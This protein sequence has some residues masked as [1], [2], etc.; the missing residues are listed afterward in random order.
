MNT[1]LARLLPLIGLTFAATAATVLPVGL[2]RLY[3]DAELA[4]HGR[5]IANQVQRDEATDMIVTYTT[6]QV[7]ET[8]KGPRLLT[9][10]IKQIGGALPG[11]PITTTVHGIPRF[12]EGK[13]Y[14]LFIPPP[15]ELGF[16]SP[17]ALGQG[18]FQIMGGAERRATITNGRDINELLSDVAPHCVPPRVQ[19]AISLSRSLEPLALKTRSGMDLE[20]FLSM[21]RGMEDTR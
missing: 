19:A 6:F 7:L 10:T 17:V 9:H 12:E 5:C 2:Q 11:A 13:E 15:S 20:D 3:L 14:V 8:L 1:G 21:V 18:R 4:F 16:S